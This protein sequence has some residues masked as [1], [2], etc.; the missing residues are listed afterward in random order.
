[1]YDFTSLKLGFGH[2]RMLS[3]QTKQGR[4]SPDFNLRQGSRDANYRI[5]I[6]R[7]KFI[8]LLVEINTRYWW[9]KLRE[10]DQ[11]EDV[12]LKGRVWGHMDWAGLTED[13]YRWRFLVFV[14]INLRVP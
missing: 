5:F 9:G 7:R 11:L 3:G 4:V 1:M 6:V 13:G 10:R 14:V 12:S 2:L 8:S